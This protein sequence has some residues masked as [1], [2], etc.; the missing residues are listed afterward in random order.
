MTFVGKIL[1]ILIMAFS[2]VFLGVSTV[3]F[4]TATNW[5]TVAEKSKADLAK[6]QSK[7]SDTESRRKDVESKLEAAKADHLKLV[8]ERENRIKELDRKI[9]DSDNQATAARGQLELAQKN[10]QVALAEAT[11]RKGETDTLNETLTKA[12]TQGNQYLAQNLELT[13]KIRILEREKTTAEQNAKDLRTFK[14]KA[15]SFMQNKGISTANIDEADANA[16]LPPV[17]G[18]VKAVN[19]TNRS[20]EITIGSNDGLKN[21]HILQ[22]YRT[23]PRVEFLGRVKIVNVEPNKA[24]ADVIGGTVNG[25]KILEGDNVASSFNAQ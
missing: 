15:I 4:S 23:S 21:G 16:S 22:M 17:Q 19:G 5:K 9:Q 13:D 18:R 11:A 20:V 25:K 10:A 7:V 3:V 12:Q 6:A 14:A 24:V 8:T 2:L 1:V